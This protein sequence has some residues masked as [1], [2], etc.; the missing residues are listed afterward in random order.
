MDESGT[1]LMKQGY[2]ASHSS[3]GYGLRYSRTYRKGYYA[4]QWR[5][6]EEPIL[7]DLLSGSVAL[8][9]DSVCLDFAC[10]TGRISSV[11]AEYCQ[12]V[13]GV[14]ISR[15]MLMAAAVPDNVMLINLDLTKTA[16]GRQFDLVSAFR[17]FLNAEEQL[18]REALRAMRAHLVENGILICNIH[19]VS[20]SPMGA[21][22][23]MARC[24]RGKTIHN[25]MAKGEF[26]DLLSDEGFVP[27]QIV[28]YG[29]LPR[30][31]HFLSSVCERL[32]L[33]VEKFARSLRLP[34]ALA[35]SFVV[36]ARKR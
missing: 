30:P 14:D 36:V 29:Y 3:P 24:L 15:E 26:I 5:D 32:V 1:E 4:A 9:P 12:S 17:F 31:G 13:I 21:V 28:H 2:R 6:I 35:Q 18:R 23:R 16:I 20:T 8:S 33:P 7:R 22:Y 11:L 27:L 19:M 25:T 10:G 34:E